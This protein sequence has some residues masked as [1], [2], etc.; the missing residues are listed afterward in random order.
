MYAIASKKKAKW[1]TSNSDAIAYLRKQQFQSRGQITGKVSS[2]KTP[3]D[4]RH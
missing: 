1:E 3:F 4:F 2:E